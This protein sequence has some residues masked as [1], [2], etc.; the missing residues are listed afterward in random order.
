MSAAAAFPWRS[1]KAV[2]PRTSENRKPRYEV[3]ATSE[4]AIIDHVG[5]W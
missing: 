2:K 3:A 1:A 4:R 5:T